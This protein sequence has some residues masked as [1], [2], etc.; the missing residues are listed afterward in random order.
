M[1]FAIPY[2]AAAANIAQT[3]LALTGASQQLIAARSGRTRLILINPSGT[4]RA[5]F[6]FAGG[7]AVADQ[8]LTLGTLG[9]VASMA[10][11][12][13]WDSGSGACPAGIINVIGTS[14][15]NVQAIEF[16]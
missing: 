11:Q 14:G 12:H 5:S 1:S 7:A 8:G 16:F 3:T 15:Q 2:S 6:N 13:I 4:N 9:V 10:G